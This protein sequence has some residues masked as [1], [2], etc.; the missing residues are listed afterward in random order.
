M[1]LCKVC[2]QRTEMYYS[3]LCVSCRTEVHLAEF[4][5]VTALKGK[6]L[7]KKGFDE[8]SS[9]SSIAIIKSVKRDWGQLLQEYNLV[10]ALY[11]YATIEYEQV[12]LYE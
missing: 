3:D 4:K 1:P 5:R 8:E 11:E 10:D 2:K 6:Y 7:T 9:I 12:S